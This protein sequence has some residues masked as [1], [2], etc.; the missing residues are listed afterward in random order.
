MHI[1]THTCAAAQGHIEV[2][3]WG[4]RLYGSVG[5][6]LNFVSFCD[7]NMKVRAICSVG[8]SLEITV[9]GGD[10]STPP[11]LSKR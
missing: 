9:G 10:G 1:V 2:N 4:C 8:Y 7:K 5:N 3:E 11:P 6:L